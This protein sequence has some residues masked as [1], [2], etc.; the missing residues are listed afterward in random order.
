MNNRNEVGILVIFFCIHKKY[1]ENRSHP[2]YKPTLTIL[3][4]L[5][6]RS[7]P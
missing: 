3:A 6:V 4:L 7:D 5:N 2:Y 1:G